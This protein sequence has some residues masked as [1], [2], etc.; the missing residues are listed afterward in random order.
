[1]EA[2]PTNWIL[3]REPGAWFL[4][5]RIFARESGSLPPKDFRVANINDKRF[6]VKPEKGPTWARI[7]SEYPDAIDFTTSPNGALTVVVTEDTAYVHQS[8]A[9]SLGKRVQQIRVD[10]RGLAGTQWILGDA[11]DRVSQAVAKL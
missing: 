5:G 10:A 1:M 6:G 8:T 9:S 4:S 3:S 2:S 11:V 7:R